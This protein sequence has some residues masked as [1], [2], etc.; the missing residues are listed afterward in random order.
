M[1]KKM[2]SIKME[3]DAVE[4]LKLISKKDNRS[5]GQQVEHMVRE[6]AKELADRINKL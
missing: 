1:A 5:Q 4:L 2:I 3:E 6:R